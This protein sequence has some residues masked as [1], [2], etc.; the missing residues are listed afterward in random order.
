[1]ELSLAE[2]QLIVNALGTLDAEYGSPAAAE[3]AERMRETIASR[4]ADTVCGFELPD[5]SAAYYSV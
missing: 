2:L 5:G 4:E 3:L 1:M